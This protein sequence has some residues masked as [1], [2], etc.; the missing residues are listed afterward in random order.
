MSRYLV[1]EI[2]NMPEADLRQLV[3]GLA[4]ILTFDKMQLAEK[5]ERNLH[6]TKSPQLKIDIQAALAFLRRPSPRP[7]TLPDNVIRV[8][9]DEFLSESPPSAR[10]KFLRGEL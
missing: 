2:A 10:T 6:K 3:N 4:A 7:I 5:V 8:P 9:L 1:P